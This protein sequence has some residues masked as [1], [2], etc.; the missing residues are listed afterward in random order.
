MVE[1]GRVDIVAATEENFFMDTDVFSAD[2]GL[3]FAMGVSDP[4]S[5]L[6][7]D[8][9][10]EMGKLVFEAIEWGYDSVS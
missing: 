10:I 7:Y 3:M 1:R 6:Q 8:L 2:E 4:N 5:F 9:P